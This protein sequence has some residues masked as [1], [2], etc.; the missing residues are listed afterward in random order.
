MAYICRHKLSNGQ[1][2]MIAFYEYSNEICDRIDYNVVFA[3][4][5]KKKQLY[6][7]FNGTKEDN[8]TLKS[9]GHCGLEALVWARRAIL[10][11]EEFIIE[12]ARYWNYTH[13][14]SISVA[15]E[16]NRRFNA[17]KKG[18]SRYGF[19]EVPGRNKK[20]FPWYMRKVFYMSDFI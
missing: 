14:I 15:G 19:R 11:F 7:F 20:D 17:Y 12:Q 8:I 10:D 2:C 1:Y 6:G 18:L 13:S 16:D 3:V 9:T 5:N 4:A